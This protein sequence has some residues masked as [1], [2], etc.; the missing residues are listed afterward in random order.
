MHAIP[1]MNDKKRRN[2]VKCASI[3]RVRKFARLNE[4]IGRRERA[5]SALPERLGAVCDHVG[6]TWHTHLAPSVIFFLFSR[7][8]RAALRSRTKEL[9]FFGI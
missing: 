4:V 9:S 6:K 8:L 2:C 7:Y 3:W 1:E 5:Q